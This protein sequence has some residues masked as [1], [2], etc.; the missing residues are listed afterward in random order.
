MRCWPDRD[1]APT[2]P[3]T[4]AEAFLL[5]GERWPVFAGLSHADLGFTGRVLSSTAPAVAADGA[6]R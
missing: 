6:P 4:A 3:S 1:R 2:R 5:L